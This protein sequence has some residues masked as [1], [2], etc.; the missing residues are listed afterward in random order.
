MSLHATGFSMSREWVFIG[1]NE[2]KGRL[3][4]RISAAANAVELLKP[5]VIVL[6]EVVSRGA[7]AGYNWMRFADQEIACGDVVFRMICDS[8]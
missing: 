7:K 5:T 6:H 4:I 1:A 8:K 2:H 3:K